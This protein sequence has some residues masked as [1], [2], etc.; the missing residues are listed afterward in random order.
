MLDQPIKHPLLDLDP[1]ADRRGLPAL[2]T[3]AVFAQ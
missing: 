2:R 3:V 1:R